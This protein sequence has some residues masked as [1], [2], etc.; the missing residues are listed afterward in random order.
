MVSERLRSIDGATT[1][2]W[3]IVA[4]FPRRVAELSNEN[5][6]QRG[7]SKGTQIAHV[8]PVPALN[9]VFAAS[10]TERQIEEYPDGATQK[11]SI[12]CGGIDVRSS[13]EGHIHLNV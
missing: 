8:C 4:P 12:C 10:H 7:N 3:F 9:D 6:Q 13:D 11:Q 1:K 5:H 2:K